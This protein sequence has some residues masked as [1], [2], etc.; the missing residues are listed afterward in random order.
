[1]LASDTQACQ[2][3]RYFLDFFSIGGRFLRKRQNKAP[4]K[5]KNITSGLPLTLNSASLAE[6]AFFERDG[7]LCTT[8][9]HEF[10]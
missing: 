7:S 5:G 2:A 4:K 9:V 10:V 1:M 3:L 8:G 6:S